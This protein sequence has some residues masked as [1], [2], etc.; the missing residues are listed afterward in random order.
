MTTKQKRIKPMATMTFTISE[1]IEA[2][3]KKKASEPDSNQ[4]RVAREVFRD[5]MARDKKAKA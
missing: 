4:S 2:W 3:I 5:A 1:E